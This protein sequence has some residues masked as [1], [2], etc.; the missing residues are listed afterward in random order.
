MKKLVFAF[1][2]ILIFSFVKGQDNSAKTGTGNV[3]VSVN[4]NSV[5]ISS[6][7]MISRQAIPSSEAESNRQQYPNYHTAVTNGNEKH[8]AEQVTSQPV[9]PKTQQNNN[10]N[11]SVHQIQPE[12][13]LKNEIK[14][15]GKTIKT[16]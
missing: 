16:E 13:K 8:T 1:M 9:N 4:E 5:Y 3:N 7:S 2:F 14:I 15:S 11:K 6:A 12:N 10:S